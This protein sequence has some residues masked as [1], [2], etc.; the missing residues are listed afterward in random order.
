MEISFGILIMSK[1]LPYFF[2]FLTI[3]PKSFHFRALQTGQ[4]FVITNNII[5]GTGQLD[6]IRIQPNENVPAGVVILYNTIFSSQGGVIRAD[7]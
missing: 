2:F 6:G 4:G 7:G 5:I 3:K 1:I